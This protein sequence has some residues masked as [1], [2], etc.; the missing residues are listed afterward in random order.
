MKWTESAQPPKEVVLSE[1]EHIVDTSIYVCALM[2]SITR[3]S[4][5]CIG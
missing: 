2:S 3:L 1:A 5:D 4:L